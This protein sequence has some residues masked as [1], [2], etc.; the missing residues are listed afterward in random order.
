ML[1]GAGSKMNQDAGQAAEIC[2]AGA[3]LYACVVWVGCIDVGSSPNL[4]SLDFLCRQ[5]HFERWDAMRCGDQLTRGVPRPSIWQ[6]SSDCG[7]V[8]VGK[9]WKWMSRGPGEL[10]EGVGCSELQGGCSDR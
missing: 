1:L 3:R 9:D 8:S 10:E 2:M 6:P 7:G 5:Q 4:S